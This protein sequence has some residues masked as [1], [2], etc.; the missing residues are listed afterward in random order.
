[1]EGSGNASS[2]SLY[3]FKRLRLLCKGRRT[4]LHLSRF[5]MMNGSGRTFVTVTIT[6]GV[7]GVVAAAIACL[8][9]RRGNTALFVKAFSEDFTTERPC[10]FF[11]HVLDIRRSF[12]TRT[13]KAFYRT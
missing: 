12:I 5:G 2:R 13:D 1:M 11:V 9:W 6:T 3:A 4:K 8:A 10:R 7:G